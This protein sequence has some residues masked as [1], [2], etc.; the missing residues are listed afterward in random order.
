MNNNLSPSTTETLGD[1]ECVAD[2]NAMDI[3]VIYQV[4]R[5]ISAN[6]EHNKFIYGGLVMQNTP[7]TQ[8]KPITDAINIASGMI[9]APFVDALNEVCEKEVL[10]YEKEEVLFHRN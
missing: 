2:F 8:T 6:A 7:A 5:Q 1:F 4:I 9:A 3:T 10:T